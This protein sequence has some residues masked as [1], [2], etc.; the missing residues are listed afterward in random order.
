MRWLT[1][2]A[3]YCAPL[4]LI[5][6]PIL[7]YSDQALSMHRN[8]S[9]AGFSLDIPLI[10]LVA[11]FFRIFYY[12]GAR[13]DGALLIQSFLMVIMQVLLLKIALD[14]RPGP[15]SKGGDAALPFA[16]A[17]KEGLW[18]RRRPYQFWQ[19]RSPKPYWQF[20]LYLFIVLTALELILAPFTGIY[21]LYSVLL[22]YIGLSVEAT[23]PL[24]QIFAN[25]RSRSCKGFRVSVLASW[26]AGDAMKMFWF[27][28]STTE[29]P[30]AFKLCG[31]FQAG[32]DCFLGIQ[33]L[34]YG[35]GDHKLKEDGS[36]PMELPMEKKTVLPLPATNGSSMVSGRRTPFEKSLQ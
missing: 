26:L 22:G 10:M 23:L 6:S 28:T 3:G 27:F 5:M 25:A 16:G 30:W 9:S 2:F 8:K 20:L 19:W 13:F 4:F 1:S 36:L 34:M 31:M 18:E 21:A 32:C 15:A 29:I 7:S 33:Y 35:N 17:A 11:S 14:H 12:P 24:P